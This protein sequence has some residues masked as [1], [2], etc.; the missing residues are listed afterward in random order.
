MVRIRRGGRELTVPDSS[1][2]EYLKEGYS[3]IDDQG[4][5][6]KRGM[7]LNYSQAM[8]ELTAEKTRTAALATALKDANEKL[9]I[10]AEKNPP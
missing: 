10:L 4:N 5:E 8:A 3:V 2:A 1:V 9:A 7:A 6:V